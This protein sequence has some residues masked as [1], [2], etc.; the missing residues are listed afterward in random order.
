MVASQLSLQAERNE[1]PRQIKIVDANANPGNKNKS[2]S[3]R[4]AEKEQK[5]QEECDATLCGYGMQRNADM[6]RECMEKGNLEHVD[7]LL[8]RQRFEDLHVLC[9][10]FDVE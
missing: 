7:A 10:S 1:T 2:R 5:E 9:C 3:K 6:T 4:K 8:C